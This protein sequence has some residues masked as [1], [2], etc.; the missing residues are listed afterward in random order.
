VLDQRLLAAVRGIHILPTVSWPASLESR[1]IEAYSRGRFALP[2]VSYV[3][4]DLA[5]ARAEL[6]AIEHAATADAQ[7]DPLGDYLQRTADSWLVATEML[8]A[9]GT[10]G[11]TVPSV[12][13]YGRPD[14]LI[15]GSTQSNLDAA[16]YFIA[17]SDELG[18]DLI[19]D[20]S[21]VSIPA[22]VLRMDLAATLDDFFGADAISV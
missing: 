3:R 17:L 7:A 19:A 2:Q 6:A 22:D 9:V 8:E 4:P 16:R 14:D 1:M 20:D 18:A 15:P 10:V 13:L 5:A 11:V 12:A 21:S